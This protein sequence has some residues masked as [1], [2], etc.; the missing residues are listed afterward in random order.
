MVKLWEE[1]SCHGKEEVV[2]H[3]GRAYALLGQHSGRVITIE[4]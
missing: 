3:G 1:V 4:M 2:V